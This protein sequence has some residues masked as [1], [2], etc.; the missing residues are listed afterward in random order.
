MDDLEFRKAALIDPNDQ[1]PEFLEKTHQSPG[2][3]RFVAQQ[4]AFEQRLSETLNI[5]TPDNLADRIILNQQLSEYKSRQQKR[6]KKWFVGSI[7]A[8]LF[9]IALGFALWTPGNV[10]G[11]QLT[12]QVI[13]HYYQDTHALNVTMDVPKNNIDSMLASYGGKLDNPIG[14]VAFLGHCIIGGHT[15][16][17]LVLDTSQGQVT[18]LILP[19]QAVNHVYQLHNQ[20]LSGIIYPSK[21]GSIAIL[22]EHAE[23][24]SSTRQRLDSSLNWII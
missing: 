6:Q 20:Q 1:S 16:V 14:K 9:A 4:R 19:T 5:K 18:V 15:G 8:S 7:A 24:I 23:V 3:Q 22:T 10:D 13:K 12:E 17:H 11:K 2:N 21:K